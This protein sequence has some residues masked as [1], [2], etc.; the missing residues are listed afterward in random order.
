MRLA[1]PAESLEDWRWWPRRVVRSCGEFSVR[2]FRPQSGLMARGALLVSWAMAAPA[3]DRHVRGYSERT[4]PPLPP[5]DG[6]FDPTSPTSID[7][8][9]LMR[10]R[11]AQL[12]KANHFLAHLALLV[13]PEAL[14]RP[15]TA[16]NSLGRGR[17]PPCAPPSA[18]ARR[19]AGLRPAGKLRLR[20]KIEGSTAQDAPH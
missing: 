10:S 15:A 5:E 12:R 7:L 1:A 17:S 3:N 6:R 8:L 9:V 18:A 14:S 13:G 2:W 4:C 16:Q 19:P 20:R 11:C